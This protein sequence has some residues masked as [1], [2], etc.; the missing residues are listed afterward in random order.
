MKVLLIQPP[1]TWP[2]MDLLHMHEPLSLEYL[3]AALKEM[4]HEVKIVDCRIEPNYEACLREYKPDVVGIT[5]YT[6]HVSIIKVIVNRIKET[7]PTTFI[8][9]GGHHAT[10]KPKGFNIKNIDLVVLGEGVTALRDIM[11]RLAAKQPLADV[12]G[13]GI[14]GSDNIYLTT[15]RAYPDLNSLPI[16]DR[17]LTTNYRKHYLA[18]W[19]KPLASIRTSIGCPHRC[20]FCA[21]W[22]ITSGK[23]LARTPIKI[24]EELKTIDEPNIFFCDDES[25]CD[26]KRME[27]LADLIME[28]GIKKQYYLYA[29]VDTIVNHPDLFAKWKDAGLAEVFVGFESFTNERLDHLHKNVT[30]EQQKKAAE[31]LHDLKINIAGSFIVDPNFSKQDFHN[32]T[33]YI[34]SLNV[35]FVSCSILT[36]LPG[37][38]LYLN[39]KSELLTEKPELFD[40]VHTVLPTTLPLKDFYS[41]YSKLYM[42]ATPLKTGLKFLANYKIEDWLKVWWHSLSAIRCVK[43][44]YKWH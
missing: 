23:Y 14:P 44:G 27:I 33:T 43:R 20:T 4:N 5:A 38:E 24:V 22:S 11:P 8:I 12:L 13:V 39:K 32:L 15:P 9:V 17:S 18:E 36:P 21:L 3:G 41:E 30:L 26:S 1:S 29:R 10:V 42:K 2:K 31:I 35:D 28:A 7:N 34:R 16:P 25:M 37:T 40:F 19:M 6:N